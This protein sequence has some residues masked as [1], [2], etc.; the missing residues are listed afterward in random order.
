MQSFFSTIHDS[1]YES[2][3]KGYFS[4]NLFSLYDSI[5]SWTSSVTKQNEIILLYIEWLVSKTLSK[6]GQRI[7]YVFLFTPFSWLD[8]ISIH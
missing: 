6:Y 4:M 7:I 3:T 8:I 2:I 5:V 1:V